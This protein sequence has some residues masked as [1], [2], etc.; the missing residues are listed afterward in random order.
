MLRVFRA[1]TTGIAAI[2]YDPAGGRQIAKEI[3]GRLRAFF[4][5][6]H[7]QPDVFAWVAFNCTTAVPLVKKGAT[8]FRVE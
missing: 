1:R 4:R 6:L 7:Q 8:Y 5:P 3:P 2:A